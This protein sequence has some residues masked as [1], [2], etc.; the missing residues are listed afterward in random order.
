MSELEGRGAIWTEEPGLG[1][2][3]RWC[4][5]APVRRAGNRA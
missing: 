3:G 2:E 5:E 4:L 1:D